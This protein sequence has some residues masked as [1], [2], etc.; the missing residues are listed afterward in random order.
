[1]KLKLSNLPED[2]IKLYNLASKVDKNSFVYLEIRRGMYGLPQAGIL[3]QQLLE[4]QLNNKGYSQENLVPGLWTHSWRPITF[5]LCVD[6][7]GV[8]YV[9]KQHAA[10][11]I[12]I[13][14]EHYTISQDWNGA[15]YTSMDIDWDYTNL[16][17]YLYM[18]SYVQDALT[19][20]RHA[21]PHKLQD[22]P[23]PHVKPTYGAKSQYATDSDPS[24]LL[25]PAQMFF[26]PRSHWNLS[27]QRPIH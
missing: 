20:F 4:K 23:Y 11:L 10:H 14:K 3:A 1:M 13:L 25:T 7:F 6:D 19:R 9:G 24:P 15:R 5:T 18:L 2:F 8:K 27:L 17:I 16:E 26:L 12:A 21:L 22:Q